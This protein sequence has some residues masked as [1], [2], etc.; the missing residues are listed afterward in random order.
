[1]ST[2]TE[3]KPRQN[4]TQKIVSALREQIEGGKLVAGDKLPT[5]QKL[6]A[7]YGVSR[8]VIREAV[9]GLKAEGLVMSRQGAGVFVLK[10]VKNAETLAL[11]SENPQTISSVIEYLELRTAMEVGA[12]GLAAL[13]C[14]PA[15]EAAIYACFNAFKKKVVA[16]ELSEEEDYAFH[17][18]IMQAANNKKFLEFLKLLGPNAIPRS[19]LR[20]QAKLPLDPLLEQRVLDEHQAIMEAVVSHDVEAAREAMSNHLTAGAERYRA[21]ARLVQ[22]M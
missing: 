20:I 12:A 21:L 7:E 8:T 9:S 18:A 3:R 11:L 10:V 5:E 6:V 16:G 17:L 22:V 19:R 4:L 1:M 2:K 13:R 14:S 15:Q